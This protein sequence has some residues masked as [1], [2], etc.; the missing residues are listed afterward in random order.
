MFHCFFVLFSIGK[1]QLM[2]A[3]V[4]AQT[5]QWEAIR[6]GAA[7]YPSCN[8]D[9][10]SERCWSGRKGERKWRVWEECTGCEANLKTGALDLVK[11]VSVGGVT[12]EKQPGGGGGGQDRILWL[13]GSAERKDTWMIPRIQ[14]PWLT[15]RFPSCVS[16]VSNLITTISWPYSYYPITLISN[17]S[18]LLMAQAS[19]DI[20]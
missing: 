8:V 4:P 20:S 12:E 11:D 3:M 16:W 1:S 13:G 7:L 10:Y 6:R 18:R 19:P 15:R 2:S 5:N 17:N 9:N 14:T